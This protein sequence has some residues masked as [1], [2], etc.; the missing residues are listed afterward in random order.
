MSASTLAMGPLTTLVDDTVN[1]VAA[2]NSNNTIVRNAFN[3]SLETASG[4]YHDGV[5]SRLPYG[6][7]TGFTTEDMFLS[8]LCGAFRK[9]GF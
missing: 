3:A 1:A 6:G 7:I 2:V 5:D 8:I 4:H 9:G